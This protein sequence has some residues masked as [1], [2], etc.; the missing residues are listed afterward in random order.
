MSRPSKKTEL[1]PTLGPIVCEWIEDMLVHGPGEIQG[2]PIVLDDEL[3]AFIWSCYE[4]YPQGHRLEGRRFYRRA[5]LSRPKGRAK[6][7]LAAMIACAE[8]L[9]PVRFAGWDE[10]GD[11]IGEPIIAPQVRCFATEEGQAGNTYEAVQYMLSNGA[12]Y[13]EYPGL[14]IGLTRTFLPDGG[15]I[16]AQSSKAQSKDGG[17][18]TFDIFD[19]THLWTLPALKRLHATVT[20]N[21]SKRSNG[22]CLETSTMYCPGEDSVAEETHKTAKKIN[23]VLFDHKQAPLDIDITDDDELRKALMYVYGPASEWMN[24][25]GLIGDFRDP[26]NRESDLRRYWLNQPWTV[27]EKFTT[28]NAWDALADPSRDPEDGARIVL[29]FDG[30]LNNDATALVGV[31]LDEKPHLFVVDAWQRIEDDPHD[32]VVPVED[33]EACIRTAAQRWTVV[34]LTADPARWQRTLQVLQSEGIVVSTFPQTDA[35]MSPATS[36]FGDLIAMEGMTHDGDERLRSH[37]LNAVLKNDYRGQRLQKDRKRSS[38]K[39]DLA[40]A[41]LMGLDRAGALVNVEPV[42]YAHVYFASDFQPEQAP[43]TTGPRPPTHQ[44]PLGLD[45]NGEPEELGWLQQNTKREVTA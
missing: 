23:D 45:A 3:K 31:T 6:S 34:E 8:A 1:R 5:V 13:E 15:E 10:S 14:D 29:A 20:R 38:Y 44:Q 16:V 36:R 17:K 32:W 41:A 27:E 43:P 21:L 11:P 18:D 26:Q 42:E 24:I 35:R 22:W 19:E 2:Q 40:V 37:V 39:I 30:S 33:V 4:L 25:D 28:P 9:G 12:V 7:E